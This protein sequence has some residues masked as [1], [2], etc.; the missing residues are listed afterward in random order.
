[1]TRKVEDQ[2]SET[3]PYIT[4]PVRWLSFD[5][6]DTGFMAKVCFM[7]PS[8]IPPGVGEKYLHAE[9]LEELARKIS[10]AIVTH[11]VQ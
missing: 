3:V 1:M 6:T 4:G 5:K 2:E 10:E 7:P 11:G 8:A 9:T